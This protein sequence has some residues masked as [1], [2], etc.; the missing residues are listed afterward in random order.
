[1]ES[2]RQGGSNDLGMVAARRRCERAKGRFEIPVPDGCYVRED[3]AGGVN[4]QQAE[5]QAAGSGRRKNQEH[6]D[7]R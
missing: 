7:A 1:M 6:P 3:I 4:P 5:R 2:K